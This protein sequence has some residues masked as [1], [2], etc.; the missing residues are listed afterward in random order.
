MSN[1][2]YFIISLDFEL[3]WGMF[4]KVTLEDYGQNITGVHEVIPKL[5]TLFNQ[6]N[7]HATWATVGM[8]MVKD[9]LELLRLLP[10]KDLQPNYTNQL[11]STYYHLE[12]SVIGNSEIDDKFHYGQTLVN[13]IIATPNQELA[14]HTFS[15]YY[16]IDGNK[17]SDAVF[18]ADCLAFKSVVDIFNQPIKSIIFPRNQTTTAALKICQEQ[19]FIAYRGTPEHFLYT[20]K[21]DT[22][23][24]NPLLRILRLMDS[25]LNISG[26][27]TFKLNST[28]KESLFNIPASRFL[29]P[30]SQ[31]LK[32]LESLK[33][34]RIKNGMTHAAKNG[35]VFHLWW[36]PHNF[37]VNQEENLAGLKEIISHYQYL[38]KA[39]Q[40]E[41]KTMAELTTLYSEST[42]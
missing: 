10:E 27:H 2:P 4:D 15:H 9:K 31:S 37:G 23:Q 1:K 25:Y 19:G 42:V 38:N 34:K 11:V 35:E 21:N 28:T 18:V 40:M 7:I 41:S 12:N 30:Y 13:K 29:R 14:S 17:N 22:A 36:H 5:L 20:A 39:Y 8:L 32:F 16:C 33:L 26:H 6:N 3:Y 24:T